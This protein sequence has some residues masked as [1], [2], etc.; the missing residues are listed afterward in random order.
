[1]RSVCIAGASGFIGRNLVDRLSNEG[2]NV[3][4][5][6]RKDLQKDNVSLKVRNCSIIVNLAGE[7]IAGLWTKR[8]RRA[9]Y[10]S[11][12]QTTRKLVDAINLFGGQV[13]LLI[14]VS[15]VGLYDRQHIHSEESIL[16]DDG[17]LSKVI[18]DWEGELANIRKSNLRIVVLRLGIVL[19]KNGGLLKQM[20]CTFKWGMGFGI[21]SEEFFPFVQLDDLMNAF[22]FCVENQKINGIVNV[23]AP[24][25]VKINEFFKTVFE[26]NS[27]KMVMWFNKSFIR[28]LM[29]ES[30]SLLTNGQQVI[31][32]KLQKLGFVFIYDNI[33]DALN[34][35]CN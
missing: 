21:K 11:R 26:V 9:I 1:M 15:G 5:I 28:I 33:K 16:Y 12:I 14:Q 23:A 24:V 27:I 20:M 25:L 19:D 3:S 30:G 6:S 4:I 10:D 29:G 2:F 18:H 31:P 35:A 17:F 22:M 13:K 32:V 7:S 8:K 34:R